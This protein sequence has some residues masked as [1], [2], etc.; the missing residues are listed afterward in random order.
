MQLSLVM[1][2]T[3]KADRKIK[4][5]KEKVILT[6]TSRYSYS[7][8]SSFIATL[9]AYSDVRLVVFGIHNDTTVIESI[10]ASGAEY[11][12]C[13][14]NYHHANNS[15]VSIFR[16]LRNTRGLRKYFYKF[17]LLLGSNKRLSA[18][19]E[20]HF[21]G[22]QSQRYDVYR[23]WLSGQNVK[24]IIISDIRDVVFQSDPFEQPLYNL[25]VAVEPVIRVEKN[26]HNHMWLTAAYGTEL[27]DNYLG[28]K[29]SCSGVTA[30]SK[31][32]M[33]DYLS[34][35]SSEINKLRG[36]VG[37]IDQAVHNHLWYSGQLG[38][39]SALENGKGRVLTLQYEDM[40]RV[41]QKGRKCVYDG[42]IVVP[43]LHQYD[44][45]VKTTK[46]VTDV[47]LS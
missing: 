30:G 1:G 28:E 13:S 18:S 23:N 9:S 27:S 4:A 12:D 25:E 16:I 39:H 40:A 3:D 38:N 11:V 24:E 14:E 22:L 43:I 34:L 37:P 6:T 19:L 5:L 45:H 41:N 20:T 31:S 35:M 17:F 15:L 8:I 7:Q 46:F 42:N 21:C 44:R 47:L 32:Q 10:C 33:M 26:E 36:F 2:C 29:V